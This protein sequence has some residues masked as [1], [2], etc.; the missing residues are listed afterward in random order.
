MFLGSMV[1][2]VHFW[3]PAKKYALLVQER[4]HVRVRA[5]MATDFVECYVSCCAAVSLVQEL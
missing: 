5:V 4:W 1:M 3:L 2:G